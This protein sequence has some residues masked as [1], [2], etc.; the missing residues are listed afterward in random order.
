[1]TIQN[2]KCRCFFNFKF[3]IVILIFDFLTLNFVK[4]L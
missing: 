1:M 2:L 3:Y 4:Y